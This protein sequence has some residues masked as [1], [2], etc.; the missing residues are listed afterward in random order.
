M[1][2]LWRGPGIATPSCYRLHYWHVPARG[3]EQAEQIEFANVLR[4]TDP[5]VIP[6]R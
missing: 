1:G 5:V 2:E 6:E 3:E 4:E